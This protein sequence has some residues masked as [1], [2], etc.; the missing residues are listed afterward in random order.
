MVIETKEQ[1]GHGAV[2]DDSPT[3]FTERLLMNRAPGRTID[4]AQFVRWLWE[5]KH[6]RWISIGVESN[7]WGARM[8]ESVGIGPCGTVWASSDQEKDYSG[9][10]VPCDCIPFT[11]IRSAVWDED[12]TRFVG[13]ALALGWRTALETLLKAGFL[14]GSRKLSYLIGKD[15][16]AINH[17]YKNGQYAIF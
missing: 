15:S 7:R 9:I 13:G 16:I 1:G 14:R 4:P 5:F 8:R 11:S 2:A 10:V 17:S 12:K 3:A 6:P